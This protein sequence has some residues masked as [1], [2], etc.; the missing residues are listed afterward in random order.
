M[1][2]YI[3][4]LYILVLRECILRKPGYRMIDREVRVEINNF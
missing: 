2:M 3:Y 4:L 1:D